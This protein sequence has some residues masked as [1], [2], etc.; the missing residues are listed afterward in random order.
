[1]KKKLLFGLSGLLLIGGSIAFVQNLDVG[2]K[3]SYEADSRVSNQAEYE[4][5]ESDELED[6]ICSTED[7]DKP[8]DNDTAED[9]NL[10]SSIDKMQYSKDSISSDEVD[11]PVAVKNNDGHEDNKP[12]DDTLTE[13]VNDTTETANQNYEGIVYPTPDPIGPGGRPLIAE[14]SATETPTTEQPITPETPDSST[15][16]TTEQQTTEQRMVWVPPKYEDVWVVDKAA[17][18]IEIPVYEE[19]EAAECVKCHKILYT[20]AEVEEHAEVPECEPLQYRNYPYSIQ[21][22][23]QTITEAEKGHYERRLVSEG[24]WEY[25]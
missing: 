6:I 4:G 19:Y 20:Q 18:T 10:G 25:Q 23:T 9:R 15:A 1:M 11:K 12:E 21:V 17:K 22:G 3:G 2:S 5:T 7:M 13:T 24:H 8:I 16:E 14:E